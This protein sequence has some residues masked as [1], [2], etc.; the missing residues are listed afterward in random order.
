MSVYTFGAPQKFP[1]FAFQGKSRYTRYTLWP[2][3]G[4]S[5]RRAGDHDENSSQW[6]RSCTSFAH[7]LRRRTWKFLFRLVPTPQ[8]RQPSVHVSAV[9]FIVFTEFLA[10]RRFLI[11][12]TNKWTPSATAARAA[13][14]FGSACPNTIHSPIQ[15]SAKPKYMG[16]LTWRSKPTTTSRRGG[17]TGA[18][19]P[20]PVQPKSQTQRR[21]TAKPKTEG[22]AANQRQCSTPSISTQKPSH[23]GKGQNQARRVRRFLVPTDL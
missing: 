11:Q 20:C 3:V 13:I 22:S 16:F 10:Q 17:A 7:L 6:R 5:A 18:G 8:T 2:S 4:H 19:V 23:C 15:P 21:A 9:L 1:Q 14:A 12:R